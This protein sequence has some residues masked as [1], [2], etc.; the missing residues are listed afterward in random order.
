MSG[1]LSN[2]PSSNY[3]GEAVFKLEID[4]GDAENQ[5]GEFASMI[6]ASSKDGEKSIKSLHSSFADLTLG[7][8]TLKQAFTGLGSGIDTIG[9]LVDSY[10]QYEV[11]RLNRLCTAEELNWL[12][13]RVVR[14]VP[15][16]VGF[17]GVSCF[18]TIFGNTGSNG[19]LGTF[20]T[21]LWGKF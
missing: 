14:S 9:G 1:T 17:A 6:S 4:L 12:P 5:L 8:N 20:A 18:L 3:V 21:L 2:G 13:Y 16:T 15:R 10:N 19:F 7:I 11:A